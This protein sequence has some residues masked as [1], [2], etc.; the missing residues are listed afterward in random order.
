MVADAQPI[1]GFRRVK[2]G[3]PYLSLNIEIVEVHQLTY[4]AKS[5]SVF[6]TISFYLFLIYIS[7]MFCYISYGIVHP[8]QTGNCQERRLM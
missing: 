3:T 8:P 1:P 4:D 2:G 7:D 6:H 5:S